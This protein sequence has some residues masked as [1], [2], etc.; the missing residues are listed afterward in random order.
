MSGPF[1]FAH[2]VEAYLHGRWDVFA[3]QFFRTWDTEVHVVDPFELEGFWQIEAGMD[4]GYYP[5]PGVVEAA[6]FDPYGRAWFHRELVFQELAAR[7]CAEQIHDV[8]T[9][10]QEQNMLIRGDTE[11]WIRNPDTGVSIA[12]EINDR[13]D[14]LGSGISLIQANKD[15]KNGWARI[16]QYLDPAR[17]SPSDPKKTSPWMYVMRY[18]EELALGCPYLIETL[19][20]MTHDPKKAGDCLKTEHD[21]PPD[22]ARYLLISRPPLTTV[23]RGRRKPKPHHKRVHVRTRQVLKQIRRQQAADR[24]IEDLMT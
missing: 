11:M 23:P 15:R 8:F 22:A 14:E 9:L 17:P 19:P 4:W 7:A 21:H 24:R 6:A 10:P 5:A 3:G 1:S 18:S 12:E 16:Y 20:A 2:R 13:L